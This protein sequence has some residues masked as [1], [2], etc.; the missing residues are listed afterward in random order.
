MANWQDHNQPGWNPNA[1]PITTP[2]TMPLMMPNQPGIPL[3]QPGVPYGQPIQPGA[4][5]QAQ[6]GEF[7]APVLG[8]MFYFI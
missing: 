7:T 8:V 5:I 4:P 1:P 6:P 3:V 2:P